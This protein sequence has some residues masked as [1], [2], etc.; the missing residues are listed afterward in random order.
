MNK[1]DDLLARIKL[2]IPDAKITTDM[3][4]EKHQLSHWAA[5]RVAHGHVLISWTPGESFRM[6]LDS[7]KE[8]HLHKQFDGGE[9]VHEALDFIVRFVIRRNLV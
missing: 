1:F 6:L 4:H 9:D 5:V 3:H 2:L 8:E 7:D